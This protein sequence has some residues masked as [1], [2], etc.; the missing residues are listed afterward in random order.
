[1]NIMK[2]LTDTIETTGKT[3][4]GRPRLTV[5]SGMV[6]VTTLLDPEDTE[7]AKLQPG[8][9]ANTLRRLLREARLNEEKNRSAKKDGEK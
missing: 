6:K 8:G 4:R 3:R 2:T 7:W 9:M 1:M 5:P